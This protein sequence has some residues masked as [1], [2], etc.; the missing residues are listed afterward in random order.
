MSLKLRIICYH[1]HF[2]S[3]KRITQICVRK[4]VFGTTKVVYNCVSFSLENMNN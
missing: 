4:V 2:T 1:L 3:D